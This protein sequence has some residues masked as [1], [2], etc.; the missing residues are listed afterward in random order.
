MSHYFPEPSHSNSYQP[1]PFNVKDTMGSRPP[2]IFAH[3]H[4]ATVFFS[5]KS[6]EKNV[7]H[8]ITMCDVSTLTIFW[9]AFPE[10]NLHLASNWK[11]FQ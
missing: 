8:E 9:N 3:F 4:I 5:G 10:G 7:C 2:D 1:V 11:H 6:S